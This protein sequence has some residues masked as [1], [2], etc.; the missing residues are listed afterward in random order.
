MRGVGWLWVQW[1]EGGPAHQILNDAW[2]LSNFASANLQIANGPTIMMRQNPLDGACWIHSY[3]PN[4]NLYSGDEVLA[5]GGE[6]VANGDD[7]SDWNGAKRMIDQA[8]SAFGKLD[9]V[10][11]N[12]AAGLAAH[13]G[14]SGDLVADLTA[15]RQRAQDALDSGA[16][17]RVLISTCWSARCAAASSPPANG[18]TDRHS[19]HRAAHRLR[20]ARRSARDW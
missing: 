5:L 8:V 12:A 6:A 4:P 11:L 16:A 18:R 19:R 17:A 13:A 1:Y 3:G 2:Y 14:L 9:A 10:V 20:R 7:V 15:G